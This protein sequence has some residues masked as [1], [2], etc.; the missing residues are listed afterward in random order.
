[1]NILIV[2]D[3][4]RIAAFLGRGLT[5]EGHM[6][7]VAEDGRDGL[8]Q[9]RLGGFDLVIL[10][11][12]LPYLDGLEVCRLVREER[13]PVL[14]L[15]L[16]AKDTIRD[17]VE[18]LKGGADDYLTKP[19]AFDELLARIDALKRRRRSDD[20]AGAITVG[21]LSLDPASRRV[22]FGGRDVKLTVREFALLR[23][24]M[25]NAGKVVSR[26]RLLNSVWEYG[27][28]PGTKIVDVYVR[29]LRKKLGDEGPDSI[30]Q[31]IRGVGY[32][33]VVAPGG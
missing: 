1:M 29:Y 4:R 6:A 11:R 23:Y 10:D 12:T 16:T 28:D 14:I 2:E 22:T 20:E 30:I 33:I 13:R 21:A 27:F 3:D 8:D 15:M 18:G 25:T 19:F 17:K 26:Q 7:T 24:L 31:T 9:I 5:A 32:M